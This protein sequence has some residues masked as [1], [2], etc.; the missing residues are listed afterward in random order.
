MTR[1]DDKPDETGE[2]RIERGLG[3]VPG[4][5][6][7]DPENF[8]IDKT[9][10][11]SVFQLRE[12]TIPPN[13]AA[14]RA[15]QIADADALPT[16]DTVRDLEP[17]APSAPADVIRDELEIPAATMPAARGRSRAL[18]TVLAVAL[19]VSA[20]TLVVV[21]SGGSAKRNAASETSAPV[22]SAPVIPTMTVPPAASG[23]AVPAPVE[24]PVK[25]AEPAPQTKPKPPTG[26]PA[27]SPEKG[28]SPAA[29]PS[30]FT[31]KP[32]F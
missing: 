8:I 2:R 18:W 7:A 10:K 5:K 15:E 9:K 14:E 4:G 6:A 28:A 11:P 1:H 27:L 12:V 16:R 31:T 29:P 19:A 30:A 13:V 25:P 3:V 26:K 23:A 17:P 22:Q 21:A 24:E 20:V 32:P